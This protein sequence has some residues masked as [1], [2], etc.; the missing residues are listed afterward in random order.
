MV[1]FPVRTRPE[2]FGRVWRAFLKLPKLPNLP[3][4]W[5]L[6][7]MEQFCI[8]CDGP[9]PANSPV[10]DCGERRTSRNSREAVEQLLRQ[11]SGLPIHWVRKIAYKLGA[12]QVAQL[13]GI[14]ELE[15]VAA[16]K[17]LLCARTFNPDRGALFSTYASCCI[18]RILV[19]FANKKRRFCEGQYPDLD[20]NF[21]NDI[22][23]KGMGPVHCAEERECLENLERL[24]LK[25]DAR[26]RLILE[27][28]FLFGET[29][30]EV[31]A[32]LG[33]TN[34]RVRQLERRALNR[35]QSFAGTKAAA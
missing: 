19:Q 17:L 10:C 3:D 24:L 12:E 7:L 9:R 16:E 21:A 6:E 35:L 23:A 15:S 26:S 1:D 34:E 8:K 31:G 20:S 27:R 14:G 2:R 32:A 18:K 30:V 33:I 4:A 5:Y 29:L 11:W 22:Q 13:G 28:R 25:L